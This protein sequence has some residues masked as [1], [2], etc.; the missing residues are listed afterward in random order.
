[1]STVVPDSITRTAPSQYRNKL[2]TPWLP[3]GS[4]CS[5]KTSLADQDFLR[6]RSDRLTFT[7]EDDKAILRRIID[8]QGFHLVN[9]TS[10]WKSLE[11]KKVC[12]KANSWRSIMNRFHDEILPNISTFG[13]S[14]RVVQQFR[15][16]KAEQAMT[17][18]SEEETVEQ[19][20]PPW[21]IRIRKRPKHQIREN[22]KIEHSDKTAPM[23][24]QGSCSSSSGQEE[25]VL[26]KS[27]KESPR[28]S[29]TRPRPVAAGNPDQD[30]DS[31]ME[32]SQGPDESS[33]EL[34][35]GMDGEDRE[36]ECLMDNTGDGEDEELDN[37]T[38][39]S[40]LDNMLDHSTLR[41]PMAR[42]ASL[43]SLSSRDASE[44]RTERL[45]ET[46]EVEQRGVELPSTEEFSKGLQPA[47]SSLAVP[48]VGV[49][50]SVR[51]ESQDRSSSPPA[52][53][54]L[55]EPRD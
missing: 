36:L 44:V 22:K 48:G 28:K 24:S 43:L 4:V 17:D 39:N 30:S 10:V 33:D 34:S 31:Y 6:F 20:I 53:L 13:L 45:D 1:M 38:K 42:E 15:R 41:T 25:T 50:S 35:V 54:L 11:R 7:R 3:S 49:T 18:D 2:V 23:T 32:S 26:G 55:G 21:K 52:L 51:K 27:R 16:G 8:L 37:A 19:N 14:A 5:A 46:G 12:R 9:G 29:R 40:V 47:D